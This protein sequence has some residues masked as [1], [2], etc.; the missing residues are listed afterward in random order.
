MADLINSLKIGTD[1]Y[2]I[3]LPYA[4]CSTAAGTAAKVASVYGDAASPTNFVLSAGAMIVVKFENTNSVSNP[5]LNINGTGAAA[6]QYKGVAVPASALIAD[7]PLEFVYDG[8]NYQLLTT[9]ESDTLDSVTSRG[10]TTTN[11]L[12]VGGLTMTG[13]AESRPTSGLIN[14]NNQGT[15]GF[16]VKSI[17]QSGGLST[18]AAYMT[19]HRPGNHAVRF[20]LDGDN[21][22]KVGGWSMGNVA[23]ELWHSGSLT[24]LNQLINGPGYLTPAS[25]TFTTSDA[26]FAI[27]DVANKNRIQSYSSG[28]PIRF[29]NTSNG[30]ADIAVNDVYIGGS[31]TVTSLLNGK[32]NTITGAATTITSSNLTASRA[33]VSDGSGKVAASSITS[34]ELGYLSGQNQYLTSTSTPT[35]STVNA[36]TGFRSPSTDSGTV[37]G[38]SWAGDT[39]TGMWRVASGQIGFTSGGTNT[40]TISS[41]AV[42]PNIPFRE[43]NGSAASPSYSFSFS[44]S[45]GMYSSGTNIINFSTNSTNRMT[46]GSDGAIQMP[47][48]FFSSRQ[49]AQVDTVANS[50]NAANAWS[51]SLPAG[52]YK[53]ESIGQLG[54][55]GT[56]SKAIQ[57]IF[58]GTN[59]SNIHLLAS[60]SAATARVTTGLGIAGTS[61]NTQ[62]IEAISSNINAPTTLSFFQTGSSTTATSNMPYIF[63]GMFTMSSAGTFTV[64]IRA[65]AT[66][67][68][69]YVSMLAGSVINIIR[70]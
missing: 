65:S 63:S 31:N 10:S 57:V 34:T 49:A 2:V 62:S 45:S 44:S 3:T 5:T 56:T 17:D 59:I 13:L 61:M 68:S 25:P 39:T 20:G 60:F 23:Y 43:I 41:T 30:Y 38:F 58:G 28:V 6:I 19:F 4:I 37:P 15:P 66:E 14:V 11:S 48:N 53:V 26:D 9:S 7:T 52:T 33:L 12:S 29:L 69:N 18:A 35:F 16:E 46:I 32:E 42:S 1:K 27:G 47:F 36:T 21:K 50:P 64:N 8:T 54:R 24:N 70:C 67:A 22:L 40:L 51:F 55:T